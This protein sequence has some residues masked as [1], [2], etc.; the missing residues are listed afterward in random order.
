[1]GLTKS[2]LSKT[3]FY[4]VVIPSNFTKSTIETQT[5]HDFILPPPLSMRKT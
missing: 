2:N 1:M 4:P 3:A 5:G